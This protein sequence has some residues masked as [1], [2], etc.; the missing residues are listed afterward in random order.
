ML[1]ELKST[2]LAK[3][4]LWKNPKVSCLAFF[5]SLLCWYFLFQEAS[6]YLITISRIIHLLL[7][8][9]LLH[10]LNLID[11]SEEVLQRTFVGV[12][13]YFWQELR[14]FHPVFT[15]EKPQGSLFLLFISL[16]LSFLGKWVTYESGALVILLLAFTLPVT[17]RKIWSILGPKA[18][19]FLKSETS[20]VE[21]VKSPLTEKRKKS[22]R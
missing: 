15:W 16:L 20:G 5:F 19:K 14:A 6:N 18:M 8:F 4:A 21:S 9:G 11:A 13:N 7:I 12:C 22:R 3:I 17:C 10:R 2:T 1:S